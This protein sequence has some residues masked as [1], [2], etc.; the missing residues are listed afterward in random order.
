MREIIRMLLEYNKREKGR[1]S[2]ILCKSSQEVEH[3][4]CGPETEQ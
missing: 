2:D 4:K 1:W 3:A